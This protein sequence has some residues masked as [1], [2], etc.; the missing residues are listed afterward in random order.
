[1]VY[2]VAMSRRALVLALAL[3]CC[4]SPGS[5]AAPR[6]SGSATPRA[7]IRSVCAE[8]GGT[9]ADAS[10]A[11]WFPRSVG[12]YCIDPNADQ[13]VFGAAASAPV[14]DAAELLSLDAGELERSG[15]ARVVAIKYVEDSDE[16]GR[17]VASVLGF[18]SPEAAYGFFTDRLARAAEAGR[19][20]YT[21][22]EAGAAAVLGDTTAYVVRGA[23]VLR[24]DFAN[25]RLPPE[26]LVPA[27]R[28]VLSALARDIGARLPGPATLPPAARLLPDAA[29][30]PLSLRYFARDLEG[31]DGV[32]PGAVASYVDG[33]ERFRLALAVRLDA[34][35]G[36]DV[37]STLRKREGS[38]VLKHSPYDATRVAEDDAQAGAVREWIFGRKG[39]LVAG[40][41]LDAAPR[42]APKG[43]PP[44]RS[45]AVLKLTRWLDR[46]PALAAW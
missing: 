22:F 31:F 33:A 12:S 1:M 20:A 19:P 13:R 18:A 42:A 11:A 10:V 9:V 4:R 5:S 30:V 7:P 40:I 28:P 15:L 36:K 44:E 43:A 32:G 8:G 3:S 39:A 46:L 2:G 6:P 29:R 25:P 35:A 26:R 34:D 24:L 14:A 16:P 37:L 23:A 45:L 21:A 41:T 38:R 27:A 17:L